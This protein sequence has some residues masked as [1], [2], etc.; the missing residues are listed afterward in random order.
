MLPG[1]IT[2]AGAVVQSDWYWKNVYR[3]ASKST[4]KIHRTSRR[5]YQEGLMVFRLCFRTFIGGPTEGGH[6][7]VLIQRYL[8]LAVP[9]RSPAEAMVSEPAG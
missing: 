8:L 1:S 2:P 9:V 4:S 6:V 7:N 3:G 5:R